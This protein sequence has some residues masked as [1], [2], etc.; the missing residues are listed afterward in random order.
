MLLRLVVLCAL[1]NLSGAPAMASP[2]EAITTP[3]QYKNEDSLGR[4]SEADVR[5]P[6]SNTSPPDGMKADPECDGEIQSAGT[7]TTLLNRFVRSSV[8]VPLVQCPIPPDLDSST[9]ENL[10]Q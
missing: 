7:V 4:N 9:M 6:A 3:P 10:H 5:L 8:A 1:W 2:H